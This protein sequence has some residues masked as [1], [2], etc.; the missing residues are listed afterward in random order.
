MLHRKPCSEGLLSLNALARRAMRNEGATDRVGIGTIQPGAREDAANGPPNSSAD[1]ASSGR[2]GQSLSPNRIQQA[3]LR[4]VDDEEVNRE[5]QASVSMQSRMGEA[6]AAER[7]HNQLTDVARGLR[8]KVIRGEF[9]LPVLPTQALVFLEVGVA[10]SMELRE[11]EQLVSSDPMMAARVLAL[12][13]AA[14]FAGARGSATTIHAAC[15]RLGVRG[16]QDVLVQAVAE[17]HIFTNS[18]REV[19]A[20]DIKHAVLVATLSRRGAD[21]VEQGHELAFTCGLLHDIGRPLVWHVLNIA[22]VP[23]LDHESRITLVDLLHPI[24][25]ERAARQWKLP[26]V[27]SDVARFHHCHRGAPQ[28]V[29]LSPLVALVAAADRMASLHADHPNEWA[30][31]LVEEEAWLD[32]R[33]QAEAAD[34]WLTVARR[35]FAMQ[36]KS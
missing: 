1:R 21:I 18:Q 6:Y 26:T 16:I 4:L 29:G 9:S 17:T 13:N 33:L 25:G 31:R 11:L 36:Q 19:A 23:N 10:K 7:R 27:I 14:T 15:M 8:E 3:H 2:A 32:L 5:P 28:E 30:K 35:I 12:A 24:V 34:A 20:Q 22:E